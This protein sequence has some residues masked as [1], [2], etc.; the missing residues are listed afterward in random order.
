MTILSVL[1]QY[2]C[3]VEKSLFWEKMLPINSIL[4]KTFTTKGM[5]IIIYFTN[6]ASLRRM[7]KARPVN[8]W[9]Y[10]SRTSKISPSRKYVQKSSKNRKKVNNKKW[11]TKMLYAR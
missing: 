4:N 5:N 9:D 11:L 2:A 7:L 1:E 10:I 8:P 3:K 6:M